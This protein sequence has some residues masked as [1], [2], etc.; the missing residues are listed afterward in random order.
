MRKLL[1]GLTALTVLLSGC[2]V[3]EN[4]GTEVATTTSELPTLSEVPEYNAEP[5][6]ASFGDADHLQ[7]VEDQVLASAESELAS[8]DY[9]I[10][11][12]T[13][14]YVSQEYID[15]LAFN[16]QEN[17]YF[18]YTLSEIEAQFQDTSYVFSLGSDG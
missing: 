16:S 11:D 18:G 13:A 1:A 14:S 10:Q 17:I 8:D 7:Y 9:A 4:T 12:V 5:S 6:F 3:P 2:S 15:E